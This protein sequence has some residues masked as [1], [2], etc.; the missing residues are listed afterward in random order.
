MGMFSSAADVISIGSYIL[1]IQLIATIFAGCSGLFTS[2]FQ[3][4][5][6][7]NNRILCS[8]SRGIALIPILI[9]GNMLFHLDGAVWSLAI[10]E[11]FACMVGLSI[12][13]GISTKIQHKIS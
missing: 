2:I 9:V 7:G 5:G 12:W 3:A 6:K 10:A 1:E 4:F 8:I 13:I 11:L